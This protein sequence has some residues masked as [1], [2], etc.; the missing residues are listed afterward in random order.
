MNVDTGQKPEYTSFYRGDPEDRSPQANLDSEH[1][2]N[3][4]ASC[5][6]GETGMP[7]G[8]NETYN[9]LALDG[10]P[11]TIRIYAASKQ[12]ADA[13]FQ[14]F[15]FQMF[16]ARPQTPT[17]RE[18]I[19][20]RYRPSFMRK[21]SPASVSNYNTYLNCYIIP[22]LG[23]KR[24]GEITV[25]DVQYL[26]D[27]MANASAHGARQDIVYGTI[28]RVGGLLNR[29]FH[30]AIDL[31][32]VDDSPVKK[33]LLSNEGE[34]SG[35]HEALPDDLAEHARK[36]IPR[37]ENEQQRL[38]M[39]LLCYTGMRREEIA[40]LKWECVH[41][42][43]RYGEVKRVVIYPDGKIP[44]IREKTKTKYSTRDFIIPEALYAIMKPLEKQS[45]FVIHGKDPDAPAPF[46][47]LRR[48]F[49][50]GFEACGTGTRYT[51]HDWRAT[52]G[53]QL[54]ENGLTSAQIADLLGHADTRM[55]ETTYARTRHEG[56]MKHKYAV[57]NL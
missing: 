5:K 36:M 2:E 6:K 57:N 14:N 27:W 44:I 29:I 24:M 19:E 56:V 39:G 10:T 52:F 9:Y 40:G 42:E 8:Y 3:A 1:S 26:Y 16:S 35:H 53:T 15:L 41:L 47:T 13:K 33:T 23:D 50:A 12:E 38:Y 34:P 30:I 17:L 55:V 49:R 20:K 22:V 7:S 43:E 31:K 28:N 48:T 25:E 45:G 21:L 11:S 32:I 37:I 54:K 51:N 4:E 46:S 18:F